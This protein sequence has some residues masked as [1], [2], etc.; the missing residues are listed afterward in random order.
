MDHPLYAQVVSVADLTRFREDHV[1]AIWDFMSLLKGL[2]HVG[3][4]R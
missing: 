4:T 1:F 3:T 2:Q